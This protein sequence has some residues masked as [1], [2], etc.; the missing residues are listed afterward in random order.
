MN[1]GRLGA[2]AQWSSFP[3]WSGSQIVQDMPSACDSTNWAMF[4][5]TSDRGEP[6]KIN[7][8][9]SR[10]DAVEN[11]LDW[12]AAR[13][14][15]DAIFAGNCIALTMNLSFPVL[16]LSQADF[17]APISGRLYTLL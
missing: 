3:S 8:C 5:R 2:A 17:T 6:A 9:R 16:R 1:P 15:C 11:R 10:T 4:F 7:C 14:S 12:R 13:A